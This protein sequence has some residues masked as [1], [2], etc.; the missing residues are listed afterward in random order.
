MAYEE[1]NYFDQVNIFSFKTQQVQSSALYHFVM[2]DGLVKE[3]LFIGISIFV[4]V[5][6]M[7]L[8]LI[9]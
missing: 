4:N 2:G 6:E 8:L 7:I 5:F 9:Q 1:K 3:L